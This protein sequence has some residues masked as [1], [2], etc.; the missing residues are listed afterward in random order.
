MRGPGVSTPSPLCLEQAGLTPGLSS[1]L[2]LPGGV[3][4][5]ISFNHSSSIKSSC[6]EHINHGNGLEGISYR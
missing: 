4:V 5:K 3:E 6:S 1:D 2:I